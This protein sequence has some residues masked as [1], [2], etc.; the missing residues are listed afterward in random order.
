MIPLDWQLGDSKRKELFTF[1]KF[2]QT[3]EG[4]L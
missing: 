2:A 4:V 3:E 1:D